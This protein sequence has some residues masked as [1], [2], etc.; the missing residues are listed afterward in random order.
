MNKLKKLFTEY[1][2]TWKRLIIFS[3]VCGVYTA[4]VLLIPGINSTALKEIGIGYECWFILAIFVVSNC[5][6]WKDAAIK[7]FVFF[8]ISQPLCFLI[9]SMVIGRNLLREYYLPWFIRTLFT[10]FGG[11]VAYQIKRDDMAG[12]LVLAV[13]GAFVSIIGLDFFIKSLGS[14]NFTYSIYGIMLIVSA[15]ILGFVFCSSKKN[16]LVYLVA[17]IL[18][19]LVFASYIL[20]Y[21]GTGGRYEYDLSHENWEIEDASFENMIISIED[22][23]LKIE[24]FANNAHGKVKIINE[25]NEEK[26]IVF[27]IEKGNL[28]VEDE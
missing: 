15:V 12:A 18:S 8:L 5:R 2:M 26:T 19:T 7:C 17:I 28:T 24:Y 20:F 13:A 25:N 21:K 3:I 16:R 10:P 4:L 9:Q 6:D 14:Y 22:D 27:R 23:A 11:A 1:E